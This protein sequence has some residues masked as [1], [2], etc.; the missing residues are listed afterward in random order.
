[1]ERRVDHRRRAAFMLE[2]RL[3]AH[4]AATGEW[5]A[6]YNHSSLSRYEYA[7]QVVL[8]GINGRF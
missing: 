1:M 3:S 6:Q 8:L 4:W 2:Y 7:R 5:D